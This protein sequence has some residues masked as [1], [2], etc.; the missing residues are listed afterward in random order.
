MKQLLIATTNPAKIN[1]LSQYLT[2]LTDSGVKLIT[3]SDLQIREEPEETGNT[4]QENALIKARFYSKKSNLPALADDGGFVIDA[5]NGEPGVKSNRWLGYKASD[6]ELITY[7]LERLDGIPVEQRTASLELCLCL[8]HPNNPEPICVTTHIS[9][10]IATEPNAHYP[11]GFPFRA[12]LKI[13]RYDKYYDQ[14]T[15]EE[16]EAVNHRKQAVEKLLPSLMK[17]IVEGA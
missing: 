9:G 1:E 14:L 15:Q 3:L 6:E 2:P 10:S 16:H 17:V 5:L 13:D 4:I 8:V 7:T 11:P 12:L